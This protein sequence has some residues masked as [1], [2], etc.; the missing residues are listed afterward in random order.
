MF[1]CIAFAAMRIHAADALTIQITPLKKQFCLGEPILVQCE[2]TN[3]NDA[4]L[5]LSGAWCLAERSWKFEIVNGKGK[6]RDTWV[7]GG[8]SMRAGKTVIPAHGKVTRTLAVNQWLIP[9][10]GDHELLGR[11]KDDFDSGSSASARFS[12]SI[13]KVSD[14]KLENTLEALV[15]GFEEVSY[16]NVPFDKAL[17]DKVDLGSSGD[18]VAD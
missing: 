1:A 12:V 17:L 15:D 13:A 4:P 3:G 18:L 10:A 8:L 7:F 11:F 6:I 5:D 16:G 2:L 9:E 14:L